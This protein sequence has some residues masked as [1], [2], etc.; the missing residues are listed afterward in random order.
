MP[1]VLISASPN[2]H[3]SLFAEDIAAKF[4]V[5]VEQVAALASSM[6][7]GSLTVL[8]PV[9]LV[10]PLLQC[11]AARSYLFFPTLPSTGDA[12]CV[13]PVGLPLW[14]GCSCAIPI[15]S[16]DLCLQARRARRS[17]ASTRTC[18]AGCSSCRR[19]RPPSCSVRHFSLVLRWRGLSH[20]FSLS[21]GFVLV[22]S[23][24]VLSLPCVLLCM[25]CVPRSTAS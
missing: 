24:C 14:S 6:G 20:G 11:S 10:A 13:Q 2:C 25:C 19:P 3:M 23:V 17:K 22:A 8:A 16:L 5:G 9:L 18:W 4:G 7:A 1:A 12:V 21:S 15:C